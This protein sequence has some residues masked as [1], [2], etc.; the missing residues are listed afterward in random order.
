[1]VDGYFGSQKPT[2]NMYVYTHVYTF[3]VFL[4]KNIKY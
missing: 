1:M 2:Y 4:K 3:V